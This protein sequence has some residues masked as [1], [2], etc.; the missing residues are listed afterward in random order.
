MDSISSS[1]ERDETSNASI[2]EDEKSVLLISSSE[3]VEVR[4][5]VFFLLYYC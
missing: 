4:E 1:V 5:R 2:D 3:D